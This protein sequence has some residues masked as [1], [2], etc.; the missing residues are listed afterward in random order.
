MEDRGE[1]QFSLAELG[2]G[3]VGPAAPAKPDSE[4]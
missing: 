3:G 2:I 1:V 4:A